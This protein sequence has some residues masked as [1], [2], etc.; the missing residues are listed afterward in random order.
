MKKII[1][2]LTFF[3][4]TC[5]VYASDFTSLYISKKDI[6]TQEFITDCDFLL[7]DSD[8]NIV[9]AWIAGYN[10][11]EIN[12][13]KK[14]IY[15][16]VERPLIGNSFNDELSVFHEIDIDSDDITEIVLYNNKID[17]PRNLSF[18]TYYAAVGITIFFIGFI[19]THLTYC[20]YYRI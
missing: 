3:L 15:K 6:N 20:K 17:T 2:I 1:L 16:L 10:V 8:N 14:G 7:Y 19:I 5:N 18:N 9:D 13:I 4:I 11:H 12:G